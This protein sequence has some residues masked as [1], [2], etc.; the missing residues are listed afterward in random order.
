MIL[1]AIT[2]LG[3]HPL[4]AAHALLR[5]VGRPVHARP[6]EWHIRPVAR[7]RPATRPTCVVFV[8][9]AAVVVPPQ[10]H[11]ELMADLD[12][13]VARIV[14]RS[15]HVGARRRHVLVDALVEPVGA[16]RGAGVGGA[17]C[18]RSSC[19]HAWRI[20]SR[21]SCGCDRHWTSVPAGGPAG[22]AGDDAVY[23][24]M[25]L[26]NV[27]TGMAVIHGWRGLHRRCSSRD[28]EHSPPEDFRPQTRDLYVPP[29]DNSFWQGA[30]RRSNDPEQRH[31]AEA[32]ERARAVHR[33]AALRR[34]R[35]WAADDQPFALVPRSTAEASRRPTPTSGWSRVS[36]HWNLDRA[37]PR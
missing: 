28:D 19:R 23:L 15:R 16:D 11:P 27:G 3:Q 14:D 33:R 7:C 26:R 22:R 5:H 20:R 35:R 34:P 1:D 18:G 21:R 4:R 12:P 13:T 8:A 36:R 9:I 25:S 37:D 32:V 24:A 6:R 31:G 29:G 10:G 30:F 17:A 2:S